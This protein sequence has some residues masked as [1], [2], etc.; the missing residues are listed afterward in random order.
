LQVSSIILVSY[1]FGVFLPFISQDLRLSALEVG[2]LQGVWWVTSALLALPCSLWFS[3]FR[4]VSL[5]LVSLLLGLPFLFLQGLAESFMVLLLARFLFVLCHVIST[6]ARPLLLQQWVAPRQYA[7]VNAVGLS[8]HSVLLAAAISTSAWLIVSVGSWRFAYGI[9]GGVLLA[10]TLA[11]MVV[12]RQGRAPVTGLQHA[13][14]VPSPS[15]FKALWSYPQGWL[16][17]FTMLALS[18]TWTAIVTFLPTL[19]LEQHDM[20]PALSGPLLGCLYYGLIPGALLGGV[21]EKKVHNRPLLL[22]VPAL[23]NMLLGVA[24]PF[25]SSRWLLMGLL[26]GVGVMWVVSPVIEVLPF[27]F[28]G[29][30]PREVAVVVSLIKTLSGLGFALGP[31]V[32]GVVAQLLGSLQM[33]LLVLCLLTGI[34][35]IAG[36]FY[37]KFPMPEPMIPLPARMAWPCQGVPG[38][39]AAPHSDAGTRATD[40]DRRGGAGGWAYQTAPPTRSMGSTPPQRQG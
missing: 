20:P 16:L 17:G 40:S 15:P 18:A 8:Q 14:A 23:G 25:T 35:V 21:L 19:L 3:R 9:L 32:T 24:I 6:P 13:L 11:W 4:P 1:T 38:C 12:A 33:G 31:M 7:L 36:W 27:E 30:R 29:I 2:L 22:W 34:S 28:P 10:Q 5:V 26:T 37:P 39:G